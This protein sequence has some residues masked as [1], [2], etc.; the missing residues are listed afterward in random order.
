MTE[1]TRKRIVYL[2][3]VA[4]IAYGVYNFMPDRRAIVVHPTDESSS[5]AAGGI[6]GDSVLTPDLSAIKAL[7]WGRDPFGARKKYAVAP[8]TTTLG[9]VRPVWTV[10]GI[11]YSSRNPM[12][13]ISG[14]TVG[15]GDMVNQARVVRIEK[16]KVTLEYNGSRF[17]IFV[18][19]G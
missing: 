13:I 9:T 7:P 2:M 15:V 1:R 19:R 3:L 6:T 17:D 16:K 10:T 14:A 8:Q 12:A 18:T 11:I 5:M 4:A